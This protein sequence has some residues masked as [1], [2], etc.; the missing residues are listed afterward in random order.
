VNALPP[1][2]KEFLFGMTIFAESELRKLAS[3]DEVTRAQG[4][5]INNAIQAD[6]KMKVGEVNGDAIREV[7]IFVHAWLMQRQFSAFSASQNS[8]NS[9]LTDEQIALS[10][11]PFKA[12]IEKPPST[13][14][15]ALTEESAYKQAVL[16]AITALPAGLKAYIDTLAIFRI[17]SA[18]VDFIIH[19]GDDFNDDLNAFVLETVNLNDPAAAAT[20]IQNQSYQDVKHLVGLIEGLLIERKKAAALANISS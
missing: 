16:N 17:L 1:T 20:K 3:P 10:L 19:K 11:P 6:L 2:V 9:P 4:L 12:A 14:K 5:E 13:R 7:R 8:V 15:S 18:A